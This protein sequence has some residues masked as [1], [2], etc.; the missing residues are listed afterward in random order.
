MEF[1]IGTVPP[2]RLW[3]VLKK[4]GDVTVRVGAYTAKR[5]LLIGT[6]ACE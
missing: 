4:Q 5:T 6:I 2:T 1:H 3:A